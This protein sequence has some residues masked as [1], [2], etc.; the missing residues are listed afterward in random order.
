MMAGDDSLEV[1]WY[2]Q[3]MFRFSGGGT[4]V[5]CDP[6]GPHTGYR[7]APVEA[8]VVLI[9]HEHQDHNYMEGIAGRPEVVRAAGAYSPGGLAVTATA[10]FHDDQGGEQRGPNLIFTWEQAGFSLV[11]FGDLGEMPDTGSLAGFRGKDIAMV[12]AGGVYTIE[13]DRAAALIRSVEPKIVFPMH[14]GTPTVV[15]PLE[16][17]ERFTDNF[18]ES[19]R[20]IADRPLTVTREMVPASTEVWVIGYGS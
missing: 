20:E 3:A 15:F 14:Y 8:D 16:P 11:H 12:P 10:S 19:L 1:T 4:T 7:F 2:G 5:V 17:L 13:P 9:S 18:P 6:V